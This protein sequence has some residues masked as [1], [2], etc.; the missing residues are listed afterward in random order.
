VKNLE[1]GLVSTKVE[2]AGSE[3]TFEHWVGGLKEH[4]SIDG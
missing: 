3:D 1:V 4:G 2:G